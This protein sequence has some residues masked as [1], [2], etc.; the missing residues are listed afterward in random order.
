MDSVT[1][2]LMMVGLLFS[3]ITAWCVDSLSVFSSHSVMF[4]PRRCA[5]FLIVMFWREKHCK[6][7]QGATLS[8]RDIHRMCLTCKYD[9]SVD[10]CDLNKY[11]C[12][13]RCHPHR[14]RRGKVGNKFHAMRKL[15]ESQ[16][17]R[18]RT[19]ESPLTEEGRFFSNII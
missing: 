13:T 6:F 1:Y 5:P 3:V 19:R 7:R 16:K 10:L 9:E 8:P 2:H 15:A 17:A 14:G 4:W 18:R 12:L 11:T